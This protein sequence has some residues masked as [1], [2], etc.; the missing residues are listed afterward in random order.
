MVLQQFEASWSG[1][2]V[3]SA[4]RQQADQL[5]RLPQ[6][7]LGLY[8]APH[9]RISNGSLY[10]MEQRLMGARKLDLKRLVKQLQEDFP[11]TQHV[12]KQLLGWFLILLHLPS[13]VAHHTQP[14]TAVNI[15]QAHRASSSHRQD[16]EPSA[17]CQE[18]I[19]SR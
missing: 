6:E 16:E 10:K 15:L 2:P 7:T 3:P 1:Q 5:K 11:D 13:A 9:P 18:S 12:G 4:A 17:I 8:V 14:C 19:T